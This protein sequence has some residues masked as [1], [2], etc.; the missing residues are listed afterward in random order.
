ME[1][2]QSNTLGIDPERDDAPTWPGKFPKRKTIGEKE[3]KNLFSGRDGVSLDY[4]TT[5]WNWS[6]KVK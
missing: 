4:K 1:L 2:K 6:R 5:R 3:L